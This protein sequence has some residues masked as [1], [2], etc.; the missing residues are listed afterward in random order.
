MTWFKHVFSGSMYHGL[1]EFLL[2]RNARHG[3]D[4]GVLMQQKTASPRKATPSG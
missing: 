3:A 4:L 2:W 1:Q